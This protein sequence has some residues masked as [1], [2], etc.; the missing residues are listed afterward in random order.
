[1]SDWNLQSRPAEIL[2]ALAS[3]LEKNDRWQYE[4]SY[5]YGTWRATLRCPDDGYHHTY[6]GSTPHEATMSLFVA[7][8]VPKAGPEPGVTADDGVT[9]ARIP[10]DE[11]M[12]ELREGP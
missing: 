5:G 3:W 6:L 1:M 2:D 10:D 9:V 12:R 4:L 11:V 8:S 7:V